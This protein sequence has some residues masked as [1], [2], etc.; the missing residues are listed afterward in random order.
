MRILFVVFIL[1]VA[2]T[3][4]NKNKSENYRPVMSWVGECL[5]GNHELLALKTGDVEKS[6]FHGSM[7]LFIGGISGTSQTESIVKFI[8]Q[9]NDGEFSP[10]VLPYEKVRF[11]FSE[12][13]KPSVRFKWRTCNNSGNAIDSV[14]YAVFTLKKSQVLTDID[15]KL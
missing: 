7:F 10:C 14:I 1:F 6:E 3:G 13:E 9:N 8:W 5:Q 2:N 15:F 4:C 11:V 12:T